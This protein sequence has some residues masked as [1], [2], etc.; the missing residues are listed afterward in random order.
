[1]S[2]AGSATLAFE[3]EDSFLGTSS[4]GFVSFGRNP[5]VQDLSID[6]QLTRLREAGKIQSVES[7]KG[8]FEGAF[9]VEAVINA[10]TFQ[11]I[12]NLIF[13]DGGTGFT[14]GRP[15]SCVVRAGVEYL[16][17]TGTATDVRELGG[18]VPTDFSIDY[19]QGEPLTYSA[20]FLYA[21]EID[22]TAPTSVTRPTGGQDGA[23]HSFS[24][25]IDATTV[26]KLQS[27]SLSFSGISRFQRSTDP[28][29]VDATLAA[30]EA[31]LDV[32]AVYEGPDRL[33]L[34]YGG[35]SSPQDRVSGVSATVDITIN[36]VGVS[37]YTLP[38]VTPESYSWD[39]LL[40]PDQDTVDNT[41]FNV[42]GEVSVA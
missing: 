1:M 2:G 27:A 6:N 4:G 19:S 40:D 25:D 21:D 23:F 12:E 20:T 26:S 13:N 9:G 16:D 3:Q 11:Q 30:P 22:S 10:E 28:T 29:P 7:L 37:T 15:Q 34:A 36:G 33:D 35:T 38:T 42:S 39:S 24:I 31:T 17:T 14:T 5:T 32:E 18:V 8:N 41:T